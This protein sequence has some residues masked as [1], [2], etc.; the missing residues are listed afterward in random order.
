MKGMGKQRGIGVGEV[1]IMRERERERERIT[2]FPKAKPF[3]LETVNSTMG[4][5]QST[6][7]KGK[8]EIYFYNQNI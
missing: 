5:E 8:G 6:I 1:Q 2:P 7:K 4:K 3:V